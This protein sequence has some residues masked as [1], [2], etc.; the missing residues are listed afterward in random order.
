MAIS[1]MQQPRQMYGLGSLVKKAV[2][3]ITGAVKSVAK[4]PLGKA[5][6]LAGGAYFAPT[7]FG[8]SAGFGNFGNL[9]KGGITKAL[10]AAKSFLGGEKNIR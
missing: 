6:L 5:A 7:L 1:R 3:G 9:I 4:S 8:Q 2:K 10:P